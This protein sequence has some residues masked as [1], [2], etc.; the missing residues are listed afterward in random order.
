MVGYSDATVRLWDV[1]Y[2]AREIH[3]IAFAKEPKNRLASCFAGSIKHDFFASNVNQEVV[4]RS[5]E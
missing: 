5:I 4:V 1:R 2:N 3:K